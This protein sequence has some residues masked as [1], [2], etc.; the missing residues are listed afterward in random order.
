MLCFYSW[1][2]D[3][4]GREKPP[5][6]PEFENSLE[7]AESVRHGGGGYFISE[8]QL[9]Y[10]DVY[11]DGSHQWK[12]YNTKSDEVTD[13]SYLVGALD[14][15]GPYRKALTN[16]G[17]NWFSGWLQG[18]PRIGGGLS[19]FRGIDF[20]VESRGDEKLHV[21]KWADFSGG[22][23]GMN[24]F[25][26]VPDENGWLY[27]FCRYGSK[28]P[29]MAAGSR[30]GLMPF[31]NLLPTNQVL[32]SSWAFQGGLYVTATDTNTRSTGIYVLS[33][34]NRSLIF[35]NL[36]VKIP[37]AFDWMAARPDPSGTHVLWLFERE[38][39]D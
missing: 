32:A 16:F 31:P 9:L 35:S 28:G 17:D 7:A 37:I 19:E 8:T 24:G 12:I 23:M 20:P 22:V 34:T 25:Y 36:S 33:L 26:L 2:F 4:I 27:S 11:S 39:T 38:P 21:Y 29:I 5:D 3:W 10:R 14:Q 18:N 15:A 13:G 6:K 1:A 30:F